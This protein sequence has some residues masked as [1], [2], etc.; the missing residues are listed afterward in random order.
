VTQAQ[1]AGYYAALDQGYY[2]DE[3]LDVTILPGS[4]SSIP[5]HVVAD[6]G[7]EFGLDWLP[8]LLVE[9]ESGINLVNIAQVFPRAGIT[10]VTWR[11]SGLT[12]ITQLRGKRVGVWCCGNQYQLFAALAKNGIDPNNPEDVQI[13]NQP[14]DMSLFLKRQT[15]AAAAMTYNEIAQVL[16]TENPTTG[17]LYQLS[18]LNVIKLAEVGTGM[19][20]DGIFV[21]GEW[22]AD[23]KNQDIARR[24]LKATFKGWVFCRD[25]FAEC[26][27]I[28]LN[29]DPTLGTGHQRW[30]L[31]EVNALIWPAPLGIGVIDPA[32]FTNTV[33]ISRE[34]GVIKRPPPGDVVR[35]DLAQAAVAALKD[36]GIDVN[37]AD[38]QKLTVEVTPGGK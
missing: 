38:Y 16:E 36:E 28:V 30:Q 21:R 22:I 23:T 17:E 31:N 35:A 37:G 1:F 5:E 8:S 11:D 33:D 32:Q 6:G 27:Q 25:H 26:L 3:S 24:F 15:D 10:E 19:L 2:K 14:F 18:D 29:H 20:E 13:V 9:R 34:F 4:A 12:T 7:A